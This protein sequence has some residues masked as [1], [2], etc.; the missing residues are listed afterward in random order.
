MTAPPVDLAAPG[1]RS[2][3]IGAPVVSLLPSSPLLPPVPRSV[4]GAQ[5]SWIGTF[6]TQKTMRPSTRLTCVAALV[7]GKFIQTLSYN[8]Y[9]QRLPALQSVGAPLGSANAFD[10]D[11]LSF[12]SA[13]QL[14]IAATSVPADNDLSSSSPTRFVR[15]VPLGHHF[16]RRARSNDRSRGSPSHLVLNLTLDSTSLSVHGQGVPL[17]L[18]ASTPLALD[19]VPAVYL[20]PFVDRLIPQSRPVPPQAA[21][22]F[23]RLE[24]VAHPERTIEAA[25]VEAQVRLVRSRSTGSRSRTADDDGRAELDSE[26]LGGVTE[27]LAVVVQLEVSCVFATRR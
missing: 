11:T 14:A 13:D 23:L 20:C 8:D 4:E 12:H 26:G 22:T 16:D 5:N 10:Y 2:Q 1:N 3:Y 25:V 6:W 19:A 9:S 24:E 21:E 17:D 18:D 27:K 15:L 7:F